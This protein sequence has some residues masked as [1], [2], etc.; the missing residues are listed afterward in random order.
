LFTMLSKCET[1]GGCG[2]DTDEAADD[3]TRDERDFV[4]TLTFGLA[5]TCWEFRATSVVFTFFN[6]PMADILP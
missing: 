2:F 3:L 5:A 1:R 4:L 6:C